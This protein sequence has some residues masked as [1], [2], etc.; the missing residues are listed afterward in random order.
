M[1]RRLVTTILALALFAL[2]AQSALAAPAGPPEGTTGIALSGGVELAWQPVAGAER[3]VVLRG[4][5][6][7]A[8]T[9]QVTPAGGITATSFRD[10]TVA[11]GTTYFYAV[12]GVGG[13]ADGPVG[14]TVRATPRVTCSGA[15][16]VVAENCFAGTEA[17]HTVDSGP[18]S[19][20]GIEGFANQS[21]IEAGQSVA[22]KINTGGAATYDIE[23]YRT[24]DYGGD[25]GRLVS[26]IPGLT[27]IAQPACTTQSNTG[28][29]DCANWST[30]AVLTTTSAWQSGVYMIRLVR[31]NGADN[32]IILTV[33]DDDST[34]DVL[35]LVPD[36]TYQA[37]NNYGG[38]STYDWN[39]NGTNTVAG[40][41]RAVKV[42]FDRPY[43]Q[44]W[45][46]Q[47]DWYSYSD[48]RMVSWL[49]SQGYDVT[50]AA[51]SDLERD[52]STVL[53]YSAVISGGHDEYYSTAMRNALRA[54]RDSGVSLFFS[55]ANAIYWQIAFEANPV[56]GTAN[57]IIRTYKSVQSGGP[58]P[59]GPTSTWR[60]PSGAN[61]P[62]NGLIGAMYAGDSDFTY[63]P[64][65]VSAAEGQDLVWRHTSVAELS[66]GQTASIGQ[67]IV[68][69]EWDARV[70]NGAEPPGV[71]TLASSPV[72]GN[73]I[74]GN[75]S[76]VQPGSTVVH[77]TK[78]TAAS[79]ALVFASGTNH[80][81]RGLGWDMSGDGEPNIT[82]QQASV[83]VLADM[84][85]LPATPGS[86]IELDSTGPPS[87]ISTSP[88][89]N[90]T[91]VVRTAN[92]TATFSRAMNPST[93]T[94]STVT[95]T[96]G[97]TSVSGTVS[98][99]ATTRRVTFDPAADL[100]YSTSY[101]MRVTT[102]ARAA[103]NTPLAAAS[104]W[105]FTTEAAPP[106]PT[107]TAT[108]PASGATGV[109]PTQP[110]RATFSREMDAS[111]FTTTTMRLTRGSTN[112]SGTVSYDPATL[113]ATFTPSATLQT[114]SSHTLTLTTGIRAADGT[115]MSA[116]VTRSFTTWA[117]AP[118]APTVTAMTP[119]AN[120]TGV[121]VNGTVTATFSKAMDASTING[122]TFTLAA[123]G[124]PA[125]AATVTYNATTRVATLTP[126][127]PLATRTTYTATLTNGIRSSD[128]AVLAQV[129]RTFTTS[130]TACPCQ[131]YPDSTVPTS[132]ANSVQDGR[133]GAGPFTYEMGVR[134]TAQAAGEIRSVRYYKSPGETGTH[135][136]RV[137]SA[138]GTQLAQVTFANETAS[139]WQTQALAAPIA[140]TEG[141]TYVVS[142]NRNDYYPLASGGLATAVSAG[143]VTTVVGNNGVYAGTAG[144]F[145]ASSW[146]NSNYYVD[147]VVMDVDAPPAPPTVTDRTPEP[148]ATG[149]AIGVSPTATFSR[150][151]NAAS[152]TAASVTVRPL[153]EDPVPA[154]VTYDAA[155]RRVTVNPT[156]DLENETIYRVTLSTAVTAA[157]GTALAAPVTWD[158][159]TVAAATGAPTFQL[160]PDTATPSSAANA[161]QDGRSGA[162]PFTYEMGVRVTATDDAEIRAI[163]FFKSPGE[164][165]THVGRLWTSGG[166]PLAQVTFTG[167]TASGWQTQ[168]LATPVTIATGTTVVVS[169]NRNAFYALSSG[170]LASA[171]S[172][173]PVSTVVG[174]NGVFGDSAGTF[175]TGSWNDSNYFTDLVVSEADSAPA[176]TSPA[177]TSTSPS[178]GAT[179]VPLSAAVSAT[180]S[181]E[182]DAATITSSSFTLT[183]PGGA[184]VP[185]AVSYAAATRTATLTPASAL[186]ANTTYTAR[187]TTAVRS[188][189]GIALATSVTR[190]FTTSASA[191]PCQL[192]PNSV[193]PS[194][195]QNPVQDG[196]TGPG[197]FS[198]EMGLKVT[199]SS[200]AEIRSIRFYKSPGETG[201][202]VGRVWTSGGTQI[203]SVTFEGEGASGW[204]TQPLAAPLAIT[205]GETYI[206]SVNRN[207]YY[208]YE[209]GGLAQALT[210][211]PLSTVVGGNGV[212][213]ETGGTFPSLSFGDA[214][215]FVDLV[216]GGDGGSGNPPNPPATPTV[217]ATAPS[218][219]ATGVPVNVS[220][221]ATFSREID[222]ATVGASS[223]TIRAT[224]GPV[225]AAAVSY[226]AANERVTINPNADLT[227]NRLYEVT[228]S[229]AVTSS[230]GA[231]LAAPYTWSFR[232]VGVTPTVTATTPAN[233]AIG[234]ARN[235]SPTVTFS[236]AMNAATI[237]SGSVI[238]RVQ[239]GA[240][241]PA[242]VTF[243]AANNRLTIDPTADLAVGTT[244]TAEVSTAVQ[245]AEGAPLAAPA[246]FSF[247]TVLPPPTVT[248][249]T[250]AS[251]ATGV[252]ID[253]SPTA[254]FSRAMAPGSFTTATATVRPQGGSAVAA[255]V[256]YDAGTNRVTVDPTAALENAQTYEVTLSTGITSADGVAIAAPVQWWFTT[257]TA[258]AGPGAFTATSGQV[259]ID[260]ENFDNNISRSSRTWNT[261]SLPTGSVNGGLR[262]NPDSGTTWSS[263]NN[264]PEI[265]VPVRFTSSG[266]WYVWVRM[267]APNSSGNDVHV[268]L[269]GDLGSSGDN[270]VT[271]SY[272][273]WQWTR[274]REGLFAQS[275]RVSVPSTG[276][277][278][279]NVWAGE[280]GVSLDRIILTTSSSY[281]PSGNGPAES[282]RTDATA[283]TVSGRFPAP[284]LTGVAVGADV[285]ATFSEA[286]NPATIT[287]SSFT[288]VRVSNSQAVTA[289]RT[290]SAGNTAFTLNPSSNLVAN[291]QYR[292]TLTTAVQ[293]SAGNPLTQQVTWTFTTAP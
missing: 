197:P 225:L 138:T 22:L 287:T 206:V 27:G 177:V 94:T 163:R 13:G 125:I 98:Y 51:V 54:A 233:G 19:A 77:V 165:G 172:A 33:R 269:N 178:A 24:G 150:S 114:N 141:T 262:V 132:L 217:T 80:W 291:T 263:E 142:V 149:V 216:I 279:L 112:I 219:G 272:N 203:A 41:T 259:V 23:I 70:D 185:G 214:N 257:V 183:G 230:E 251:S 154:A 276:V 43:Q 83:N 107:V 56:T 268:G 121:P 100:A 64:L 202:H 89:N 221:T 49:E 148:G 286:I 18:A 144:T 164:T 104:T 232:T 21:S 1:T 86:S 210:A 55:G 137:W 90:A 182:M 209:A 29:V 192:F 31:A 191:C 157:D 282:A 293:D 292:A 12:R 99:N 280:D 131:L 103:D 222:A 4:T 62:E 195:N 208:A 254:T 67:G 73:L 278:T 87:V 155:N 168:Q 174:G 290:A 194:T 11:N 133:N 127:A 187:L 128:Q 63:Y 246:T 198:Y 79:G 88:A 47:R 46:G 211:G 106:P 213:A 224:N 123:A 116:Q 115:A 220:P 179:G 102:G 9:T 44:A 167:E 37:Y 151:M 226:D 38:R 36:T 184:A 61:Q 2:A 5:S 288:L 105:T 81:N 289:T 124:S 92:P 58:D 93:L 245:S 39:S 28:L 161:V 69:W 238:L 6:A 243:D 76:H 212:F 113:T 82:I 40:A 283:P 258:P 72:N 204:Q 140:I 193:Q 96:R 229:P 97:S 85:A 20:N 215:Y 171:V 281:T 188:A 120:A 176:P 129:T 84:G 7:G 275:A 53:G 59:Q 186:A 200:D 15:N 248:A 134:V 78:Y 143:P 244:Y 32:H 252:A 253:A 175:P 130:N 108:V 26:V 153:G 256:S 95:M 274:T 101:T 255:T 227:N 285:I 277:H 201:T 237:T 75:G 50:Y 265:N 71:T 199:S 260:V 234:V 117:S 65:R 205:A 156:A 16:A 181:R 3:Y 189:D 57:R 207:D 241:V 196:R 60:D 17:W 261:T 74:Q 266:T 267:N 166:S 110:I 160:F 250:P 231:P 35:Y 249:T 228:I 126:D 136:G 52:P 270:I 91:G 273:S 173:G 118:A 10:T 180:F 239:G 111:S 145:P 119:A 190:T 236:R 109:N 122:T 139:G 235:V 218:P 66:P 158:L 68:G 25:Q 147:M 45:S 146:N 170:A 242:T 223:V 14:T 135:V 162:G 48:L 42:S 152:F 271:T 247:T 264:S 169:V 34:A 8:I 284:N 159:T 240:T 30:S